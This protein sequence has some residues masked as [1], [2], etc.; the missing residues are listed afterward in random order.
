MFVMP[1]GKD[2]LFRC[3]VKELLVSAAVIV[4]LIKLVK[5]PVSAARHS[6]IKVN[7]FGF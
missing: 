1:A 3:Q 5:L 6:K 7:R 4:K 2:V